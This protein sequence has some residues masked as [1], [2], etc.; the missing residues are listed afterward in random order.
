MLSDTPGKAM[1]RDMGYLEYLKRS[2]DFR[3][4]REKERD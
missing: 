2:V 3:L 4:E 1:C